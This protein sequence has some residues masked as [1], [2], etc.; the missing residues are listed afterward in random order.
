M[1]TTYDFSGRTKSVLLGGIILGVVCLALSFFMDDT[2]SHTR[3]W[4]NLLQ[5]AAFFSMIAYT[6][7]FAYTAFISAYAGWYTQFKR[8]FEAIFMFL[9]VGMILMII[10][11]AG[12]FLHSH[13]LYHW[14]ADGVNDPNNPAYDEILAG[15]SSFLNI[16]FYTLATIGFVGVWAFFAWKLRQ[17]SIQEDQSEPDQQF[18][19]HRKMRFWAALFLPFGA[20]TSC[21]VI[22][23]WVMS[24]DAHW[25]STL[26]AWYATASAWVAALAFMILLLIF[27]KNQG[28]FPNVTPNH[29]HDLGK[30]TFGFSVFW[31]Y[32]W[33]S[34]YMLIWYSNVGE[35]TIYF[36][37][38]HKE[39][40]V[41]FFGNLVLNFIVPFFVLMRND[42]KRKYGTLFFASLVVFIGHWWDYF[43]M[44]KPG[45][46]LNAQH[47]AHAAGGH[48]AHGE[49][50]GEAAHGAADAAHA[51]AEHG[52]S[53]V[54]G[55]TL[56]GLIE[57]GIMIGFVSLFVWWVLSRLASAK[58]E[59]IRDPYYAES[60]HH[61]V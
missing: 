20:F 4:S 39:Y 13:H 55:F 16:G 51:V 49:H 45:A 11:L 54:S 3:F 2:P 56:P 44:V 41:M 36:H 35:E 31:T 6:A 17:L 7:L 23:Q 9:P 30:F 59:P 12:T 37:L 32:L 60:L 24:V 58:L 47:A 33:F 46:L 61:Q 22:W 53:F 15:K 38:R 43:L 26:F 57:L 50:A 25:Y 42:T 18:A 5:N 27:L 29:F 1:Q 19:I 52:S 14:A 48:G 40:P 21:A 34:Q 28:Y 8:V 10:V